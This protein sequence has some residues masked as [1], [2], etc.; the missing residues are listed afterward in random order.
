MSSD[1]TSTAAVPLSFS[2]TK[3]LFFSTSNL[4]NKTSVS[5][6]NKHVFLVDPSLMENNFQFQIENINTLE[7][8]FR[9]L[10]DT[11]SKQR[12]K[13]P[14]AFWYYC[15]YCA[16]LLEEFFKNYHQKKNA[17]FYA[18]KKAE[19]AKYLDGTSQN[20]S[21]KFLKTLKADL[22]S[23]LK[24]IGSTP[25]HITEIRDYLALSNLCRLYWVFTRLTLTQA[26]TMA[27]NSHIFDKLYGML[28]STHID[29][30]KILKAF[31]TPNGIL[32]YLSVGLF[33]GR[34]IIEAGL[35]IRHTFFPKDG[36]KE[37][38]LLTRFS[39]EFKK[40]GCNLANDFVWGTIN[41]L[42]NFNAISHLPTAWSLPLT[43]I[44]LSFDVCLMF[45]K[46]CIAERDYKVNRQHYW[47]EEGR[48]SQKI[49][50]FKDKKLSVEEQ[51]TL[52]LL[53]QRK[54][55]VFLQREELERNWKV[56][57]AKLKF[58]IAAASLLM[59]GFLFSWVL[60]PP[61]MV[62]FS[63]FACVLAAA[64]YFSMDAY[65]N[66]KNQ[67]LLLEKA[68]AASIDEPN[69]FSVGKNK[70]EQEYY[71]ARNHF[72]FTMVKNAILPTVLITTFAVCWPAA[73]ALT[74]VYLGYELGSSLYKRKPNPRLS[75]GSDPE[76][77]FALVQPQGA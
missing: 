34:F 66:Y 37:A 32:N 68:N 47:D 4:E 38:P 11:L 1:G 75:A 58:G 20:E 61:G 7:T 48:L 59:T 16:T 56:T 63:F 26:F 54:K 8:E 44:F 15:Y 2:E 10:F 6:N 65:A 73:V 3:E 41:F 17:Q 69:Q 50:K 55:A 35:L 67:T 29:T 9:D 25:C 18:D 40:R 12:L 19:I 24:K 51:E 21:K 30:D 31:K 76:E 70:A 71:K 46:Y 33:L 42:C 45:L 27:K 28:G 62:A 14:N 39:Y 60:T 36:E 52:D 53:F 13:N 74:V 49:A 22:A 43:S 72:I 5:I 77:T 64:M 57:E 23:G